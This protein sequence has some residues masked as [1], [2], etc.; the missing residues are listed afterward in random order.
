MAHL[1]ARDTQFL[2]KLKKKQMVSVAPESELELG[3]S[4]PSC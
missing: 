1:V 2:R 3:H 4:N